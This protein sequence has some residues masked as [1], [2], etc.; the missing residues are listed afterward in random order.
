MLMFASRMAVSPSPYRV[1]VR[2]LLASSKT[3]SLPVGRTTGVRVKASVA[4][5]IGAG[6]SVGDR[7]CEGREVA[8][9]AAGAVGPG[10]AQ[11]A[12]IRAIRRSAIRQFIRLISPD[13]ITRHYINPLACR[14]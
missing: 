1:P 4:D 7:V 8:A 12:T 3:I 10:T 11:P 2:F 14:Q 6:L 13:G 5:T 9:G